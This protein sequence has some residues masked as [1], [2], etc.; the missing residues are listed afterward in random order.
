V[1]EPVPPPADETAAGPPKSSTAT[2]ALI[3]GI[4]SLFI[5]GIVLGAVAI[6]LGSKAEREIAESGGTMTGADRARWGRNLGIAGIVL[7]AILL[8]LSI[9]A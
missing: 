8:I 6:Y 5:F 9:A 7:W 1:S 4:V 2:T 3:L